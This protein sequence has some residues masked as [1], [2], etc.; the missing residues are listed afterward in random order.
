MAV[1]SV[2]RIQGRRCRGILSAEE[3]FS[4][5][6]VLGLTVTTRGGKRLD[7]APPNI[8][9]RSFKGFK[10]GAP[11]NTPQRKMSQKTKDSPDSVLAGVGGGGGGGDEGPD[12]GG[13]PGDGGGDPTFDSEGRSE[14]ILNKALA[15]LDPSSHLFWRIVHSLRL[16][17][18]GNDL[19]EAGDFISKLLSMGCAGLVGI[20]DKL[21]ASNAEERGISAKRHQM[22]GYKVDS[23]DTM[24]ARLQKDE[25][26]KGGLAKLAQRIADT[27]ETVVPLVVIK[28]FLVM[29]SKT[30]AMN[31]GG[32]NLE[33]IAHGLDAYLIKHNV[34]IVAMEGEVL[35]RSSFALVDGID[36]SESLTPL[37]AALGERKLVSGVN[38]TGPQHYPD[39]CDSGTSGS[40]VYYAGAREACGRVLQCSSG[41]AS[42]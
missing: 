14:A 5:A 27:G 12:N 18:N 25:S 21:D 19:E 3:F 41:Q 11:P 32:C 28:D 20:T 13:P 7:G 33:A 40:K 29:V 38:D 22:G 36:F 16:G 2:D 8:K 1:V 34:A 24:F 15:A 17:T 30:G 35:N 23:G 26:Y 39:P 31:S 37:P 6:G 10:D 42:Q 4:K 9:G